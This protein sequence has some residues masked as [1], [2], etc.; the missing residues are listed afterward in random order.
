M[1]RKGKEGRNEGTITGRKNGQN[2]GRNQGGVGVGAGVVFVI[3][4]AIVDGIMIAIQH[5]KKEGRTRATKER[6]LRMRPDI[7]TRNK[8]ARRFCLPSGLF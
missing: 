4:D 2:E 8:K 3:V 1:G 7:S 5:T 6:R